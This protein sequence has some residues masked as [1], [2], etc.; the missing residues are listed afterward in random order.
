MMLVGGRQ[1]LHKYKRKAQIAKKMI[2]YAFI[3]KKISFDVQEILWFFETRIDTKSLL[4]LWNGVHSLDKPLKIPLINQCLIKIED[5]GIFSY[6]P[7]ISFDGN[8][9]HLAWRISGVSY[10]SKV[11]KTGRF[12][13]FILKTNENYLGYAQITGDNFDRT[14]IS[15]GLEPVLKVE[16]AQYFKPENFLNLNEEID[17]FEDP[18][19]LPGNKSLLLVHVRHK[20]TSYLQYSVGIVNIKDEKLFL[21]TL[22]NQAKIEKN[23]VTMC[24]NSD[25]LLLLRSTYPRS[26]LR[27]NMK[28]NEVFESSETREKFG[29]IH[30]GTNFLLIDSDFYIRLVRI[31]LS[32]VGRKKAH[33]NFLVFHDLEFNEIERTQPFIF[34]NIGYEICNS[35]ELREEEVIFAWGEEDKRMILGSIPLQNLLVWAKSNIQHGN[36]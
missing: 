6:N 9:L 34:N 36:N 20:V 33:Y 32:S 29:G 26:V 14:N 3:A 16:N 22:P 31:R 30:N 1:L 17:G 7:T 25:E 18:R 15:G 4:D 27:V 10:G 2:E 19:F 5:N 35:I 23:W 21:L 11:D 24:F 12:T 13:E 8:I 28:T